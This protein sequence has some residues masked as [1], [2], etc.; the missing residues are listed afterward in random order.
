M[1]KVTLS[2]GGNFL[3]LKYITHDSSVSTDERAITS[4]TLENNNRVY[5]ISGQPKKSWDFKIDNELTEVETM[6]LNA[7]Y[8]NQVPLVLT[9]D[10]EGGGSYEVFFYSMKKI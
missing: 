1:K 4:H 6:A 5:L 10:W 9:T 2:D 7:L 3:E 8:I